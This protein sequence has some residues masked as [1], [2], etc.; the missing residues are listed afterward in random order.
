MTV[1]DN[2][3]RIRRTRTV[4]R[5]MSALDL[6]KKSGLVV[7]TIR[8]NERNQITSSRKTLTKIAEALGVTLEELM[9]I[10]E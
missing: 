7:A 2:I 9:E 10:E 5:P 8:K 4:E 6:A 1:G 3:K